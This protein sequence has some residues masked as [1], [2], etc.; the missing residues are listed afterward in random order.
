VNIL[1]DK[2]WLDEHKK[3][4]EDFI[5]LLSNG[6]E[7][8]EPF[9]QEHLDYLGHTSLLDARGISSDIERAQN[10]VS[11]TLKEYF[12]RT[13]NEYVAASRFILS[14]IT[15]LPSVLNE[16]Y[17]IDN[18]AT[19]NEKNMEDNPIIQEILDDIKESGD[20]SLD[21]SRKSFFKFFCLELEDDFSKY[22]YD[23]RT[24]LMKWLEDINRTIDE[25]LSEMAKTTPSK[26]SGLFN[27]FKTTSKKVSLDY[28]S[29]QFWLD[30]R[31]N[32]SWQEL[33]FK[34]Q[35][36]HWLKESHN[37]QIAP[38]YIN[39]IGEEILRNLKK[40]ISR[41]EFTEVILP[42]IASLDMQNPHIENDDEAF[43]NESTL[44]NSSGLI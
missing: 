17:N 31:E 10:A 7:K 22:P 8:L 43:L 24:T 2:E 44:R 4:L 23:L 16:K 19:N 9:P 20:L 35:A 27:V 32:V 36:Y 41:L 18:S 42:V 15:S 13:G 11:L 14:D 38:L 40:D 3:L 1:I 21:N 12:C 34:V 6:N 37:G 39:E 33:L 25:I 26:K 29:E 28:I 30:Y 5:H